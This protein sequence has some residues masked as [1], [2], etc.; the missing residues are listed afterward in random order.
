MSALLTII[1]L[2]GIFWIAFLMGRKSVKIPKD[3]SIIEHRKGYAA[4][5]PRYKATGHGN[6][7]CIIR[8]KKL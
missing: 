3:C 6:M 5:P 4:E 1:S 8:F 7:E 2:L